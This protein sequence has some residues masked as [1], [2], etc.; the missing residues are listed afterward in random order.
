MSID[1][2]ILKTVILLHNFKFGVLKLTEKLLVE[3]KLKKLICII[4]R[5]AQISQEVKSN[6]ITL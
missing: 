5:T 6:C 3:N 2:T 4:N 1:G